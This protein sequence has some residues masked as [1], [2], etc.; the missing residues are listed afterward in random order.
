MTLAAGILVGILV[1][2]E[3]APPEASRIAT[4]MFLAALAVTLGS[5][6]HT[7]FR[8]RQVGHNFSTRTSSST[9][10]S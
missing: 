2:W 10:L 3:S 6:W 1:A 8:G 4:L 5:A 9:W 7:H